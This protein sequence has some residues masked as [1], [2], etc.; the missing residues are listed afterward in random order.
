MFVSNRHAIK[1]DKELE[2]E[3]DCFGLSGSVTPRTMTMDHG[4]C[5][6]LNPHSPMAIRPP[7]DRVPVRRRSAG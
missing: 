4:N 5:D 3:R 1:R 2:L 7:K 6:R